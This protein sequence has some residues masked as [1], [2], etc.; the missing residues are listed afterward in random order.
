MTETATLKRGSTTIVLDFVNPDSAALFFADD[1]DFDTLDLTAKMDRY[2][3]KITC[4]VLHRLAF[5]GKPPIVSCLHGD[6]DIVTA[7]S[8]VELVYPQHSNEIQINVEIT[9][10]VERDA[11]TSSAAGEPSPFAGE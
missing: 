1:G 3:A 11:A 8:R 7:I 9:K 6:A 4:E 5:T 10:F 2:D